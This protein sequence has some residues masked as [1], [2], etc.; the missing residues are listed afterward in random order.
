MLL[1]IRQAYIRYFDR[2]VPDVQV[3]NAKNV[4]LRGI[5]GLARSREKHAAC[6]HM[7]R[8]Y[9]GSTRP[10]VVLCGE[11]RNGDDRFQSCFVPFKSTSG[12]YLLAV[13]TPLLR[14]GRIQIGF[15][16]VCEPDDVLTSFGGSRDLSDSDL[17]RVALGRKASD[18]LHGL[19]LE[20]AAVP[21]PQYVRRF[22][23]KAWLEY[24][25]LIEEA[26]SIGGDHLSWRP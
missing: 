16:N 19:G 15:T 9:I 11:D 8:T 3:A 5:I 14:S 18:R 22:H 12:H 23:H 25:M 13:L 24:M 7:P 21:H 4:D 20:H 1:V 26:I 17:R 10:E 2:W 6:M